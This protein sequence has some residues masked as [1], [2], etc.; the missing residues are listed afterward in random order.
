VI[1]V[2]AVSRLF[3][4]DLLLLFMISKLLYLI[5]FCLL[6]DDSLFL[7]SINAELLLDLFRALSILEELLLILFLEVFLSKLLGDNRT[8]LFN[9]ISGIFLAKSVVLV[10]LLLFWR[11]TALLLLRSFSFWFFWGANIFPLFL[12]GLFLVTLSGI[13]KDFWYSDWLPTSN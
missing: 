10:V 2:V 6:F 7:S 3:R 1:V 11:F 4:I 12:L 9:R 5:P 13:S 8:L